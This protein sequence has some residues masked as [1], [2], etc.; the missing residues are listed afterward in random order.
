MCD[1]YARFLPAEA[2]AHLRHAAEPGTWLVGALHELN[3][4]DLLCWCAPLP[5][6]WN[7]NPAPTE[8]DLQVRGPSPQ[9]DHCAGDACRATCQSIRM[10]TYTV[11]F[12][13]NRASYDVV[14]KDDNGGRH[15]PR[16]QNG[17]SGSGVDHKGIST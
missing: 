16:V 6:G 7:R 10:T 9:E 11:V 2:I 15:T 13:A 8:A 14:V 1:R 3:G 17:G 5:R 12:R 4:R